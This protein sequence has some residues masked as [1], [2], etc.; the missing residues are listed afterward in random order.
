MTLCSFPG[1]LPGGRSPWNPP[2][3]S[4]GSPNPAAWRL[5]PLPVRA[6]ALCVTAGIVV[7]LV[8]AGRRYRRGGGHVQND[9]ALA[10]WAVPFGLI[11][12][13]AHALLIA[14]RHDFTGEYRLW[15][16][17]TTGVAAIG[18]P[19]AVALGAAGAWIACRRS[20]LRLGPVA[21]A[22]APAVLFGLAIGGLANWWA[23]QF[24]GP[25]STWW[26]AVQISPTH[27]VSGYENYG[28]FQPAFLYQS[29]WDVAAGLGVIWAARRF[30]LSGERTFMLGAACYAVGSFWVESVRIGPLPQVLGVRYGALG[31]VAVFL[32][33]VAGL[34]LT[35]PRPIPPARTPGKPTSKALA[36]DSPGDVMSV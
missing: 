20:G 12:A 5:G 8:V 32:L 4:I 27:R 19:G 3:A 33:A 15:H 34:Y 31:D 16:A 7:A 36:G 26:W 11:G 6:Y 24:Y 18:V 1:S 14:T 10:A 21:G 13:A 23:Q 29:L 30:A 35:R 9:A 22:A 28:T 17:V 25:P 2:L